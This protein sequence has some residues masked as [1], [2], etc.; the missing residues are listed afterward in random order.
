[1]EPS[2]LSAPWWSRAQRD[3]AEGIFRGPVAAHP[4]IVIQTIHRL[5]ELGIP[6]VCVVGRSNVGKSSLINSL[7]HG[8]E[9]ARPS[10]FP[11]RTRHLFAFDIAKQI[12]LVDLPGYGMAK[13][14]D[15]LTQDWEALVE[16]YMER[17]K[18]LKRVICLIDA[19]RGLRRDDQKMWEVIQGAGR[20]LQVVLTKADLCHPEDLHRNVAEILAA[21]Q[22]MKK[23][24]VWPYVHAVSAAE[25][26]GM[27]E[28]RASLS[29]VSVQGARLFAR[30]L[31]EEK[32]LADEAK[33]ASEEAKDEHGSPTRETAPGGRRSDTRY[34]VR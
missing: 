25:D 33:K 32:R 11:G 14:S 22:P 19:S 31:A 10:D 16:A 27:R 24:L 29:L 5:P 34:A 12:S 28:L 7:V 18:C 15:L 4:V 21:L 3:V 2:N 23:E 13:V 1:Y 26:L 17:S 8:K 20:P 30:Q 6:Q 9:I